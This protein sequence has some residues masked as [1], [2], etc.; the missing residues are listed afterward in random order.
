MPGL[1]KTGPMGQGSQTGR[2]MGRCRQEL[3]NT[4][5][6]MPRG[7]GRGFGGGRQ[8]KFKTED[9][10]KSSG[11]GLSFGRGRGRRQR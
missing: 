3:E 4:V 8:R 6:E 2:K 1:D 5:E 10:W 11:D 9:G 7:R